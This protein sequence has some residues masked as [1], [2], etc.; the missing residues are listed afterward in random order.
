[1][2]VVSEVVETVPETLPEHMP[3]DTCFAVPLRLGIDEIVVVIGDVPAML[4]KPLRN[5][6]KA[7]VPHGLPRNENVE[8]CPWVRRTVP[9]AGSVTMP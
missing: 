6:E 1:M 7:V 3:G 2:V 8:V 9:E 4:L 5:P